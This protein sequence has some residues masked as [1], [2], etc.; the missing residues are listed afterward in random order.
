[1]L[2]PLQILGTSNADALTDTGVLLLLLPLQIL[3]ADDANAPTD[4]EYC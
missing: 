2:L 1:M 4:T 3:D